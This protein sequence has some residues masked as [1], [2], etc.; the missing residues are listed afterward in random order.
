M[1]EVKY[2]KIG[3]GDDEYVYAPE[4]YWKME[5]CEP[6]VLYVF[7]EDELQPGGKMYLNALRIIGDRARQQVEKSKADEHGYRLLRA[8]KKNYEKDHK[9]WYIRKETPYS[10]KMDDTKLAYFKITQDLY[11]YYNYVFDQSDH[12]RVYSGGY[13]T[14]DNIIRWYENEASPDHF[15]RHLE[16]RNIE[17]GEA[18]IFEIGEISLNYGTGKYEISYWATDPI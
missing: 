6:E 15:I 16:S 17:V 7:K 2:L 3:D 5:Q 13:W 18:V 10:I 8:T 14:P 11:D 1:E 4:K 9:A 12:D